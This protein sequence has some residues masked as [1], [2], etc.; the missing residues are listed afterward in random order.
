MVGTGA[1]GEMMISSGCGVMFDAY[2]AYPV[3]I[4]ADEKT[5]SL[6]ERSIGR[7]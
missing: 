4:V 6:H 1:V 7:L 2:D 5:V 3:G